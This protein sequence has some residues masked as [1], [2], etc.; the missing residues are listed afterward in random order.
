VPA[1]GYATGVGSPREAGE[2]A[3]TGELVS[4]AL[5]AVGE[6]AQLGAAVG[7]QAVRSA[8]RRIPRP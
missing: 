5:Q 1:A 7:G 4:T 2:R 3:G 8:L 6:L